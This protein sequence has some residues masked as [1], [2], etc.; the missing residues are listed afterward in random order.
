MPEE[1]PIL[2]QN[3][4][5][6]PTSGLTFPWVELHPEG[7]VSSFDA[8]FGPEGV[9]MS[10]LMLIRWEDLSTAFQQLLGYSVRDT[11]TN[12]PTLRRHL[13]WQHP[14]SAQLFVKSIS[15]MKGWQLNELEAL[16]SPGGGIGLG[17]G[18]PVNTGPWSTFTYATLTLHFWRPPYYVRSDSDILDMDGKPQEWLRYVDKHWQTDIQMLSR[19]AQGFVWNTLNSGTPGSVGCPMAKHAI[20]RRWYQIPER[21]VFQA[22][23]DQTPNGI[24]NNLLYARTTTTNPITGYVRA[25]G[26]NPDGSASGQT[27]PGCVNSPIGGGTDDSMLSK[28]FF[29]CYMG[30]LLYLTPELIPQPLQMPPSLMEIPIFGANEAI[31]QQQYDVVFHFQLFDPPAGSTET[32]RGHNLMPWSGNGLWYAVKSKD[33]VDGSRP[34][35][36]NQATTP[37]Q[38][39]DFSDLFQIL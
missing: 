38:Y 27:L 36:A 34:A 1:S 29:G 24:P 28:R 16:V 26:A 2:A 30:T 18:A 32:F 22:L 3:L 6:W 33:G 14:Y 19:E 31:S 12:P 37:F 11:S 20:S 9:A 17:G 25:G 39:A 35:G 13:P 5:V 23:V 8:A 7:R 4:R 10:M 21:A 15:S